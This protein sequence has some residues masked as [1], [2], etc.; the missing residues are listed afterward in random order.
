MK[1][2][3]NS[4]IF[5]DGYSKGTIIITYS[6]NSGTRNKIKFPGTHRTAYLPDNK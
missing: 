1:V 2:N 4:D 3:K 6:M 5:C